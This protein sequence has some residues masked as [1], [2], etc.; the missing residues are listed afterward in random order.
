MDN[1]VC[2]T[3][4]HHCP[5]NLSGDWWCCN[6]DSEFFLDYTDYRDRCDEWEGRE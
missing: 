5:A 2:G 1:K 3:C 6:D 4:K